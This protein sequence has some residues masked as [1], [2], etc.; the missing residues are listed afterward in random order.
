MNTCTFQHSVMTDFKH[1]VNVYLVPLFKRGV[2]KLEKD[3]TMKAPWKGLLGRSGVEGL[4]DSQTSGSGETE[5][6][7]FW[8]WNTEPDQPRGT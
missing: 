8:S 3:H 2:F 7:S 6:L 4:L 1:L 5:W